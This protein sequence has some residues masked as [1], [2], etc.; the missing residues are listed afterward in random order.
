MTT[1]IKVFVI[2]SST[3]KLDVDDVFKNLKAFLEVAVT[4]PSE[5]S[6][7]LI[8]IT[9]LKS[10]PVPPCELLS[11]TKNV[12][13]SLPAG[14]ELN[15]IDVDFKSSLGSAPIPLGG[16]RIARAFA[17]LPLPVSVITTDALS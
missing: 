14:F 11:A 15:I 10:E 8:N 9:C 1:K 5:D 13:F 3:V 4:T 16:P 17:P 7:S 12:E 6:G 2:K